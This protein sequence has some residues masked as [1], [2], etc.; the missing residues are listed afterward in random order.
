MAVHVAPG[1][2]ARIGGEGSFFLFPCVGCPDITFPSATPPLH[3]ALLAIPPAS[4]S[5]C[6]L[7]C[8]IGSAV[9]PSSAL[10][11]LAAVFVADRCLC[12]VVAN[13][14][15]LSRPSSLV[16]ILLVRVMRMRWRLVAF[17]CSGICWDVADGPHWVDGIIHCGRHRKV[18]QSAW[19]RH[20]SGAYM[21]SYT[22][23]RQHMRHSSKHTLSAGLRRLRMRVATVWVVFTGGVMHRSGC[24]SRGRGRRGPESSRARFVHPQIFRRRG[25]GTRRSRTTADSGLGV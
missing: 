15:A 11:T 2:G 8:S 12:G 22:R 24:T 5:S 16:R 10:S 3:V 9:V 19:S 7:R 1:V 20:N 17:V 25:A 18:R 4:D 13:L 14:A 23:T 21:Q 6:D